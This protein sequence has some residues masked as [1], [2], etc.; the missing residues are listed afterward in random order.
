ML[1]NN[2]RASRFLM[3]RDIILFLAANPSHTTQLALEQECAAIDRELRLAAHRDFEFEPRWAVTID[4]LM[5]QLNALQ[6]TVIHFSGHGSG[7]ARGAR[8]STSLRDI[9][10]AAGA[11]RCE[12]DLPRGRARCGAARDRR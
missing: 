7:G 3:A 4:E 8:A 2:A 6:P 1:R 11:Q 9:A 5:R 10:A 12:R